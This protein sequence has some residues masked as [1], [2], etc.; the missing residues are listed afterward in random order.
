MNKDTKLYSTQILKLKLRNRTTNHQNYFTNDT[1]LNNRV[2]LYTKL[3]RFWS[4]LH[5]LSPCLSD[6]ALEQVV[7]YGETY[8][9]YLNHV[10]G[11]ITLEFRYSESYHR[12]KKRDSNLYM[13][14][15]L[16]QIV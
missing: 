16:L 4:E 12:K 6:C 5:F 14:S 2:D 15:C 9:I 11:P 10:E 7:K 8:Y 1:L 3:Q 13:E